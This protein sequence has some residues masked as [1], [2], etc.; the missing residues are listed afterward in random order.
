[1]LQIFLPFPR[2]NDLAYRSMHSMM[3]RPFR[4]VCFCVIQALVSMRLLDTAIRRR[5]S[6]Q[7]RRIRVHQRLRHGK[8]VGNQAVQQVERHG[9]AHHDAEDLGRLLGWREGIV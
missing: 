8:D 9:L 5:Q 1:M 6:L 3:H 4:L 2:L 7:V